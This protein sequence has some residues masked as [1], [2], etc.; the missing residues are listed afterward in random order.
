MKIQFRKFY[1]IGTGTKILTKIL[2]ILNQKSLDEDSLATRQNFVELH[3]KY[4][5]VQSAI[6]EI[7]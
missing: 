3:I 6:N 4:N 2:M 1:E 7:N 5:F